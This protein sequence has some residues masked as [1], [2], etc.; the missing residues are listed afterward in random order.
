VAF[1][2]TYPAGFVR[3]LGRASNSAPW[4]TN[5]L[6]LGTTEL[7]LNGSYYSPGTPPGAVH[8]WELRTYDR[9]AGTFVVSHTGGAIPSGD[10][11][12]LPSWVSARPRWVDITFYN[13]ANQRIGGGMVVFYD[14]TNDWAAGWYGLGPRLG[15]VLSRFPLDNVAT[16]EDTWGALEASLSEVENFVAPQYATKDPEAWGRRGGFYVHFRNNGNTP[17]E[18]AGITRTTAHFA[19]RGIYWGP[20]NEMN[21]SPDAPEA[22]GEILR[23][24]A[25]WAGDPNAICVV[26]DGV[27]FNRWGIERLYRFLTVLRGALTDAEWSKIR[28]GIHDYN[29]TYDDKV[30]GDLMWNRLLEICD[31]FDLPLWADTELNAHEATHEGS[32]NIVHQLAQMSTAVLQHVARGRIPLSR[33]NVYYAIQFGHVYWSWMANE[34]GQLYPAIA[35]LVQLEQLTRRHV[36]VTPLAVGDD[37]PTVIAVQFDKVDGSKVV[38]VKAAGRERAPLRFT[39]TGAASLDVVSWEGE[40]VPTA[41]GGDGVLAVEV[42]TLPSHIVAPAG[43]TISLMPTQRDP[44]VTGRWFSSKPGAGYDRP[45]VPLGELRSV[46]AYSQ[47]TPEGG[48]YYEWHTRDPF[49]PGDHFGM[50]YPPHAPVVLSAV[51]IH[52]PAPHLQLATI[53]QAALELRSVGGAWAPATRA[54]QPVII[55]EPY[56]VQIEPSTQEDGT[57]GQY[58]AYHKGTRAW[59]LEGLDPVPCTGWRLVVDAVTAGEAP[60]VE[61]WEAGSPVVK[62]NYPNDWAGF[63]TAAPLLYVSGVAA[64]GAPYIA[65]RPLVAAP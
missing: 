17:A 57:M 36:S 54:G 44:Q 25:V 22:A 13:A 48:K 49:E 9:A 46:F 10:P 34:A 6:G 28:L 32:G 20:Y 37:W 5:F 63:G 35:W 56:P 15:L 11:L 19:G 21:G 18:L 27:T 58:I 24:R 52:C 4:D 23:V 31:E 39:V 2:T 51:E 16:A 26:W 14:K 41:I 47:D 12:V 50:V 30:T 61:A 38:V 33:L 53:K 7:N 29:V 55:D 65:R 45:P 60:S 43:V 1:N 8:H 62:V 3:V 42:G 59:V 40:V 64:Y